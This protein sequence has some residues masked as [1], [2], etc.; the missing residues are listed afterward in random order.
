[1]ISS[2][3]FDHDWE[4]CEP[5]VFRDGCWWDAWYDDDILYKNEAIRQERAY[6]AFK[7]LRKKKQERKLKK[8]ISKVKFSFPFFWSCVD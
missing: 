6:V 4:N 8:I 2:I 7:L 1:M 5:V 3:K